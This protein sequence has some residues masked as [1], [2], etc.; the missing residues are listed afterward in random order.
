VLISYFAGL[1]VLGFYFRNALNTDAV[2]Y[3]RI[4]SYYRLES[5]I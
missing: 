2:A 4:A 3:L 5:S 1:A